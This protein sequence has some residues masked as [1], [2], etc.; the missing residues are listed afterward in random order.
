VGW[1]AVLA[2]IAW[3][4]GLMFMVYALA[5]SE[6]GGDIGAL[7]GLGTRELPWPDRAGVIE[8]LRQGDPLD[9]AADEGI[10][11]EY[12][13]RK[14][15]PKD[16]G[17]HTTEKYHNVVAGLIL[18][19]EGKVIAAYPETLRG[20]D[21]PFP[22]PLSAMPTEHG[23]VPYYPYPS[24][25]VMAEGTIRK[26]EAQAGEGTAG[27]AEGA[28][29][30]IDTHEVEK[31][32]SDMKRLIA[33][34]VSGDN[35]II[36]DPITDE[37]GKRIA[38]LVTATNRH[39][40]ISPSFLSIESFDQPEPPALAFLVAGLAALAH[41]L[42]AVWVGLDGKWRGTNG[43]V[44][45]LVYFVM[46]ILG[47]ALYLIARPPDPVLCPR[48]SRRMGKGHTSCPY[49]GLEIRSRCPG[50]GTFMLADWRFCPKC[51]L[52]TWDVLPAPS[53]PRA[54]RAA[55]EPREAHRQL[56]RP[57]PPPARA[58]HT[59]TVSVFDAETGEAVRNAKVTC[60]GPTEQA[61]LLTDTE[62]RIEA[63]DA[64]PGIYK[65]LI[66]ATGYQEHQLMEEL[67]EGRPLELVVRVEPLPGRLSGNVYDAETKLPLSP[68]RIRSDSSRVRIDAVTDGLGRFEVPDAP[69]GPCI[70]TCEYKDYQ[71][72]REPCVVPPGGEALVDFALQPED[73][74]GIPVGA[75]S[76][77]AANE[78]KDEGA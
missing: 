32:H 74:K 65:M 75:A 51:N 36:M 35:W 53:P 37:S 30:V 20:T 72:G 64:K 44:W 43:F 46:I 9:R 71:A 50:C 63:R 54:P 27:S 55:P 23:Y 57:T 62:G 56:Q 38:A 47:L 19:P 25:F 1:L 49:C 8:Q 13:E 22:Y 77:D 15:A 6:L 5:A 73:G 10:L 26:S 67:K 11:R 60:K 41:V 40:K 66:R 3:I 70:L 39:L 78:T 52:D 7:S 18:N 4:G 2:W 68:A 31:W 58:G 29:T 12:V 14:V 48:C 24:D 61:V 45:A 33:R 59:I 69:A 28:P 21:L 76:D 34:Q 42:T 16:G 17:V